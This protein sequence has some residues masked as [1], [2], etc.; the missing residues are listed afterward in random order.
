MG[1]QWCMH[2]AATKGDKILQTRSVAIGEKKRPSVV[3]EP[4]GLPI[5]VPHFRHIVELED[6]PLAVC[7]LRPAHLD[8]VRATEPAGF[9]EVIFQ[10]L[11]VE[12]VRDV[13]EKESRM[14]RALGFIWNRKGIITA[15]HDAAAVTEDTKMPQQSCGYTGRRSRSTEPRKEQQ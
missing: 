6:S 10:T 13:G 1:S 7:S 15:R 4:V 5:E 8:V 2:E 9:G 3:V 14:S 12:V 11:L